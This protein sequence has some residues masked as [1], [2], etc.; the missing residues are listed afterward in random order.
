MSRTNWK[1]RY[2]RRNGD[3][4]TKQLMPTEDDCANTEVVDGRKLEMHEC[5]VKLEE[6][7]FSKGG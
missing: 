4:R 5:W 6:L 3:L 1:V 2:K 7:R